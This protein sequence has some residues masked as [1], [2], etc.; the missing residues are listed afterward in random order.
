[1]YVCMYVSIYLSIYLSLYL[2]S[3]HINVCMP[4]SISR[5]RLN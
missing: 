2:K 3:I 4:I 1:M 5:N